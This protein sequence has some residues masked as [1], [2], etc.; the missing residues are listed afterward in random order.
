MSTNQLEKIKLADLLAASKEFDKDKE[1]YKVYNSD[2]Y[3]VL[4]S[5]FIHSQYFYNMNEHTWFQL[6]KRL[7]QPFKDYNMSAMKW[8]YQHPELVANTFNY[9]M[10]RF[11]HTNP[12]DEWLMRK[13]G[14][15][16]R[17]VLTPDY[18]VL[19]NTTLLETLADSLPH[20]ES[21]ISR[22]STITPDYLVL[23]MI[24]RDFNTDTG[25]Y[26]I[27][28]VVS[29]DEIGRG[30][31]RLG[32][33]IK[34]RSCDNSIVVP[35][36]FAFFHRTNLFERILDVLKEVPNLIQSTHDYIFKFESKK[37]VDLSEINL[38]LELVAKKLQLNNEIK[39]Q[40]FIGTEG[41]ENLFGL[42]NGITHAA[43]FANNELERLELEEY[44]AAFLDMV[45]SRQV[46]AYV[47]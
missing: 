41:Q 21:H 1:D 32:G 23:K 6:T 17:A 5:M 18:L 39:D 2:F 47:R 14:N 30:K 43:K 15:S 24:L 12:N 46:M 37:E 26:G 9:C 27:G 28:L 29:N 3:A 35:N 45:E 11:N 40:L 22:E 8:M 33:L 31:L 19:N 7:C 25:D 36:Q 16:L 10:D 20:E 4:N 13:Y 42:I 34:R 38:V 44:S